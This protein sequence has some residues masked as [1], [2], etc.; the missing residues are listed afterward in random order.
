MIERGLE[1]SKSQMPA[2][3]SKVADLLGT[4]EF[5]RARMARD[6]LPSLLATD[7]FRAALGR[8]ACAYDG[9]HIME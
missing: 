1:G 8:I 5:P 9:G 3:V 7:E 4:A 6:D 2:T